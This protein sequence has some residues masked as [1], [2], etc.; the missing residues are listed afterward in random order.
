MT[1]A[2]L[3]LLLA[4]A[5][6]TTRTMAGDNRHSSETASSNADAGPQ[7]PAP[8]LGGAENLPPNPDVA[9]RSQLQF[10]GAGSHDLVLAADAEDRVPLARF[11]SQTAL[12][13]ADVNGDVCYT[14]RTYKMK[15][16]ERV[17]DHDNLFRGY[18]ECEMA[19]SYQIRSAEAHQKKPHSDE[20]PRTLK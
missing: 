11:R 3:S 9:P 6:L 1:L 15:R 17:R 4:F 8:R 18:S 19:S 10:P 5:A 14:M 2:W 12:N 7:S 20:L 13:L 16:S